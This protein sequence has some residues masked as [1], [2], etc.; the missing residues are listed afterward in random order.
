MEYITK[1]NII[2][3]I[4]LIIIIVQNY[5]IIANQA[6]DKETIL[7]YSINQSEEMQKLKEL[8]KK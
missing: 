8:L 1:E 6:K 2:I 3:L 4:L 5:F 7:R